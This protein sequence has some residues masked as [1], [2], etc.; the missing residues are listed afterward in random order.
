[1]LKEKREEI[2]HERD[3]ILFRELEEVSK[4]VSKRNFEIKLTQANG[5]SGKHVYV[6][7][8]DRPDQFYTLKKLELNI[9]SLYKVKPANRDQV[10]DQLVGFLSDKF[11]YH[12]LR[13][14]VSSFFESIPQNK[15]LEKLKTDQLLCQKSLKLITNILH[16]YGEIANTPNLGIPR[17]LGVSSYLSELYM[18]EFDQEINLLSGVVY[19][20]RYVDDIVIIFAPLPGTDMRTKRLEIQ[21]L[22]GEKS[23]Q[24]NLD[25][26]KTKESPVDADGLP[27]PKNGWS[28][29][30]LGYR[31][32]FRSDLCVTMSR[33]RLE[34]YKNRI[35][36]SF[37]RYQNQKSK[38]PRKAYRL[39]NKRIKFLTSNTQ[40]SHNKQNAYVGIY[41][42]NKHVNDMADFRALD[43]ILISEIDKVSSISLKNRLANYKFLS[44]FEERIFRR[45]HQKGEFE[46]IVRAWK[47][48]R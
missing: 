8:D 17:G 1:M 46:E 44:G 18:R 37:K 10:M 41:F 21:N 4:I 38:N 43:S 7:D 12:I 22:L 6:I 47:Y 27:Q 19:Y 48:E 26:E 13:T 45:F 16:Q 3:E 11:H 20:A 35:F 2:R 33:K 32:K 31:L 42:S 5:P 24:M 29:E 28:F 14:D 9:S 40:L 34:K 25:H 39:L 30:Y 15:L 36:G 23:L